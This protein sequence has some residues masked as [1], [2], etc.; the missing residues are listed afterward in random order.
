MK[1][2][3]FWVNWYRNCPVVYGSMVFATEAIC[4]LRVGRDPNRQP[5]AGF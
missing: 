4:T 5:E 2:L 1:A 3:A